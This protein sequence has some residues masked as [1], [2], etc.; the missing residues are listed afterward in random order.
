MDN[1]TAKFLIEAF[2][3]QDIQT[4]KKLDRMIEQNMSIIAQTTKT[5]GRVTALERRV[6]NIEKDTNE[7]EANKNVTKG[8]DGVI[9]YI[10]VSAAIIVGFII[11][12]FLNTQIK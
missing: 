6:D 7:L 5:N 2:R 8:R 9:W 4:Q 10:I 3:A 11:Q 1:E 12:A